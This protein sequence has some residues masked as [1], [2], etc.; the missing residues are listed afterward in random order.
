MLPWLQNL[1][2]PL[3]QCWLECNSSI[4]G[5]ASCSI[6]SALFTEIKESSILSIVFGFLNFFGDSILFL[7]FPAFLR[8]LRRDIPSGFSQWKACRIHESICENFRSV[9]CSILLAFYFCFF[10]CVL[11]LIA[12]KFD[13]QIIWTMC[14]LEDRK[15]VVGYLPLIKQM[16]LKLWC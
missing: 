7:A 16:F 15:K 5:F 6:F 14:N 12:E 10:S 11:W 13:T 4:T 8:V 1:Y 9:Q 3:G 2:P